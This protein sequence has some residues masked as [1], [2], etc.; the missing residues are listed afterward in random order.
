[1]TQPSDLEARLEAVRL[2]EIYM[3]LEENMSSDSTDRD[4]QKRDDAFSAYEAYGVDL[5]IDEDGNPIRCALSGIPILEDERRSRRDT[6]LVLCSALP[7]A[8]EQEGDKPM[9]EMVGVSG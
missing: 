5:A 7:G 1:M 9:P 6:A 3:R 2:H 8:D 4:F